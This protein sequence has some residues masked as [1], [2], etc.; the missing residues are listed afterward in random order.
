M[1][2]PDELHDHGRAT[3]VGFTLVELLVVLA[4]ILVIIV[5]SSAAA[6]QVMAYQ[7]GSVSSTTL[8]VVSDSLDR[9]WRYVVGQAN[10]EPI[11][12]DT[13]PAVY[14]LASYGTSATN[15]NIEKRAR[16]IYVLMRLKQEF[17]MNF[18]EAIYPSLLP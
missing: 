1:K 5:L 11:S 12:R 15:Q 8:K 16:V 7:R 13:N 18:S 4:I 10:R 14:F 6:I 2:R 3:R 9:Q 17:P